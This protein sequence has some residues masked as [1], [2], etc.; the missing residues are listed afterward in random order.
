MT[1]T[2][3]LAFIAGLA[4]FLSPCVLSLVPVYVGYLTGRTASVSQS[5][6]K[7][8]R[9]GAFWHGMAFV[10]GFT[11][12]FVLLGLTISVIGSLLYS[13][14][15]WLAKIGGVVVIFFGLHMTG[16]LRIP[17]LEF[18][19]RPRSKIDEKRSLISSF[20]LGVFFSAGWS[21]C[22]GPVLGTILLLAMNEGSIASGFFL[23]VFY[24]VGMAIP[25]LIA[26]VSIS[27]VAPAII[28][29]RK[30]M[31]YVEIGMGVILIVVGIFLF[32]GTFETL[33]RFG[34]FFDI[35]L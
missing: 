16:L 31:R 10:I 12:V 13:A 8:S 32:L 4:S 5:E 28:R 14:R 24:S 21:P 18:D 23:L 33:A 17:F 34:S 26:A 19:L 11:V 9:W 27:W 30:V 3:W 29:Y 35:G 7:P 2:V 6:T 25:F 15:D 20:L 22:V 1:V